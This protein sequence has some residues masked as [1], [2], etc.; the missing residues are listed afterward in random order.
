VRL[1][2]FKL[3]QRGFPRPGYPITHEG[4]VFGTVTSGTLSPSLGIGIGMG[5][6]PR[7]LAKPGTTIGITIRGTTIPAEVVRPPFYTEG[8]IRR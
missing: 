2:G 8:S 4:E 6:L 3:L 5:Y 7:H 1:V